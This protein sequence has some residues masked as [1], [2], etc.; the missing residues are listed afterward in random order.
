[1][2]NEYFQNRVIEKVWD[3][4]RDVKRQN[5]NAKLSFI[6]H[7]FGTYILANILQR[8]FDFDAYRVIFC[9]SVVKYDFPFEQI[10]R[11]FTTPILNEVGAKDVYPA[12]AES[13]TWGYGS[14]GTYGAP[15]RIR[16][17]DPQ[18]R[19]LVLYP[20][21]LRALI[22]RPKTGPPERGIAIGLIRHWQGLT[23]LAHA[24]CAA[25]ASA[26]FSMRMR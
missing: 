26:S 5:Q 12:L 8:E 20:A 4:I 7:S 16:T 18:I 14:A 25:Q 2:P 15:E 22:P 24:V 11:R 6:A 10:D 3:Q 23:P 17:A 9:G 13:I 1:M 21:E 19:S